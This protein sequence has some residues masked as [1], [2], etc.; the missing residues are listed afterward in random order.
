MF[1]NFRL[2]YDVLD[3]SAVYEIA[4]DACNGAVVLMSG[5]VRNQTGG[6]AVDYLDYQA[7]ESMALQVFQNISD[8]CHQKFPDI[9]EVVIHHRLGK[10]KIGEISVLVAISSPHRAEAFEACRYA[11]DSLKTDAPIWKKEFWLDGVSSWVNC[12]V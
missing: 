10:L 8:R 11:I 4:D 5:M 2:T 9:T 7:Y 1:N 6:R 3:V 12:P